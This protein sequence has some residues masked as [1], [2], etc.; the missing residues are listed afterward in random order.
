MT[1]NKAI[2]NHLFETA[3]EFVSNVAKDLS[4]SVNDVQV[5]INKGV[6]TVQDQTFMISPRRV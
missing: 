1:I 5:D 6:V 4:I 3:P 2:K